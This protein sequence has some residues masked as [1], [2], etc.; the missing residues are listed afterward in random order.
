MR[1]TWKYQRESVESVSK[2]IVTVELLLVTTENNF[3]PYE[4]RDSRHRQAE[5][6]QLI[7]IIAHNSLLIAQ[8]SI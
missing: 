2:L 5:M 4:A 7:F 6:L 8:S 1:T 3:L